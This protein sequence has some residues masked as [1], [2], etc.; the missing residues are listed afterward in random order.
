V[1]P[2]KP[3]L[4]RRERL[5]LRDSFGTKRDEVDYQ[6]ASVAHRIRGKGGSMD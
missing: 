4:Q 3:S 6:V 1:G 5:I 2:S